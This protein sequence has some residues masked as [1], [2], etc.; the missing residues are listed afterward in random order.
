MIGLRVQS[1][2]TGGSGTITELIGTIGE[3]R[4]DLISAATGSTSKQALREASNDQPVVGVKFG[5]NKTLYRYAMAAL[6]PCVTEETADRFDIQ[7]GQLLRSTKIPYRER[8]LL[9]T[10]YKESASE[11]LAEYGFQIGRSVNSRNNRALFWQPAIPIDQTPLLF[12]NGFT[13][14]RGQILKGLTSGGVYRRH[15]DYQLEAIQIAALKLCDSSVNACLSIVQQRLKKYKFESEIIERKALALSNLNGAAARVELERAINQLATLSPDIVLIFLP[16][17]D[18]TADND[19]GGSLY[20]LAYSQLLRRRIAS[21]VVY[22]D[23]LERVEHNQILNQVIPGIL[24]KLGN[25]PFI[26]AEPLDIADHFIGLDISRA[27]KTKL[28]GTMNACASVRLYGKQGE[29]IRYRLEDALLEGEEIPQRLLERL[30]PAAE[31]EGKTVLIYRDGTF[32]GQEVSHLL[33]RARAINSRFILVECI[34]SGIP[35]LYNLREKILTAPESGLGLCL[36]SHQAILVTTKVSES[37][38]LARPWRLIIHEQGYPASIERVIETTLKL[39]LLHHGALKAPRLPMPIYGADRMAYLRLNGIYPSILEGD[40][41]F[42][43]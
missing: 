6:R 14:V 21:Q 19:D 17:G 10:S 26:L 38:G 24:A 28:P 43:L 27:T 37:V 8:Q 31:L 7:Y 29:F 30:L 2:E 25:L 18:R 15:P 13:G 11:S 36:S 1:I 22:A 34:K 23:T 4:E 12:G 39:T 5:K 42:W 32:C 20:Q 9:L 3:Q 35:R 41:Q 33:E 40:R 16:M